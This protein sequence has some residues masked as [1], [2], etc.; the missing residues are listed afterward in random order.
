MQ[1]WV[2]RLGLSRIKILSYFL[3]TSKGIFQMY[4]T[5]LSAISLTK[6]IYECMINYQVCLWVCLSLSV[7]LLKLFVPSSEFEFQIF[8]HNSWVKMAPL[9]KLFGRKLTKKK[10]FYLNFFQ[11]H[12][13]TVLALLTSSHNTYYISLG[14]KAKQQVQIER[15]KFQKVQNASNLDFYVFYLGLRV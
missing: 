13:G 8:F 6:L 1:D 12:L 4:I 2:F 10:L 7:C 5:A 11:L 9:M 14:S 15:K 3:C